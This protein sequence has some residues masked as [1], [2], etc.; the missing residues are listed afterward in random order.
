MVEAPQSE[1]MGE[2]AEWGLY[3]GPRL[4]MQQLLEEKVAM[5]LTRLKLN[6]NFKAVLVETV[7]TEA[8]EGEAVDLRR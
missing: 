4:L 2:M 7:D 6:L 8:E 3:Q 1:R 5:G